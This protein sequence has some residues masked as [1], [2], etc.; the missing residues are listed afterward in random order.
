MANKWYITCCAFELIAAL[1]KIISHIHFKVA[2][3]VFQHFQVQNVYKTNKPNTKP[4]ILELA[5][6]NKYKNS[7]GACHFIGT[8]E[9]V[10]LSGSGGGI[11][12]EDIYLVG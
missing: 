5:K 1:P 11:L 9:P 12:F 3:C 4:T 7:T 6:W 8:C 2:S 10:L